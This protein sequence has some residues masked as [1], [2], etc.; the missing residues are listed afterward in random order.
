MK[1]LVWIFIFLIV[2]CPALYGED[3]KL[4][5]L[6]CEKGRIRIGESQ[7]YVKLKCGN[8]LSKRYAGHKITGRVPIKL[9][10]EDGK[11]VDKMTDVEEILFMGKIYP[12]STL[13]E[14]WQYCLPGKKQ[15]KCTRYNLFFVD[16]E[17]AVIEIDKKKQK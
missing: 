4:I 1:Y 3:G 16:Y 17:L 15:K 12:G 8:P 5:S 10:Y 2:F 6:K 7:Y 9:E 13:V 11:S 14:K